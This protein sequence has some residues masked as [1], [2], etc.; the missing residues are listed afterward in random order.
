MKYQFIHSFIVFVKFVCSGHV[1]ISDV[2]DEVICDVIC[3][4][5]Y[6][7]DVGMSLEMLFVIAF[8]MSLIMSCVISRGTFKSFFIRSHSCIV[9]N[10]IDCNL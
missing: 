2:I 6:N 7:V 9:Y 3:G 5:I 4:V 1:I 10:R 8:V